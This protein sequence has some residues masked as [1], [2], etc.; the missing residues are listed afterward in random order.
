M[1]NLKSRVPIPEMTRERF[2]N[3]VAIAYEA[4]FVDPDWLGSMSFHAGHN[5]TL[6]MSKRMAPETLPARQP[7]DQYQALSDG[8]HGGL[9]NLPMSDPEAFSRWYASNA[10]WGQHPFEIVAGDRGH[11]I[12]LRVDPV[13]AETEGWVY[14]LSVHISMF[15]AMA[16]HMALALERARVPFSVR[17]YERVI[18]G[19]VLRR[20]RRA[21]KG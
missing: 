18:G 3:T 21:G 7:G 15:Y 13:G 20:Q 2:L 9:L 11:G 16:V 6:L 4:I 19:L 10:R 12:L 5:I 1:R 8:R 17:D 14:E